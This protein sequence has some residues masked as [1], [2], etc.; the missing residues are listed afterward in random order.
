MDKTKKEGNQEQ[1]TKGLK[2]SRYW[3]NII[4]ETGKKP[5]KEEGQVPDRQNPDRLKELH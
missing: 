5:P 3:E 1:K 4:P 2:N